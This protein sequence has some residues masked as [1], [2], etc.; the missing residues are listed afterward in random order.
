MCK[1]LFTLKSDLLIKLL[2]KNKKWYK[3]WR[4]RKKREYLFSK[5]FMYYNNN[6][7]V[8]T[9]FLSKLLYILTNYYKINVG[10]FF[11]Y[12]NLAFINIIYLKQNIS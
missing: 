8:S 3:F 12:K 1:I 4:E 10:N 7:Y 2:Y 9:D 11:M 6:N 5:K